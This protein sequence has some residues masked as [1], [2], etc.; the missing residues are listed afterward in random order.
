MASSAPLENNLADLY[1]SAPALPDGGKKFLVDVAP[2]LAL[3]AGLLSLWSAYGIWHWARAASRVADYVNNISAV[4][5][6][7]AVLET[8]WT[9][10]L[11]LA[12]IVAT[13]QAILMIAAFSGLKAR[14]KQGWNL[15]YYSLLLNL[16][17]GIVLMFTSYGGFGSLIA[18]LI[19]SA[20]GLYF[21]FQI[22]SSYNGGNKHV[23]HKN[24]DKS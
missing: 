11:W 20:I 13:I 17:Y 22:R 18:A 16:A 15:L 7:G 1:K 4:Y 23:D 12:L 6:S 2:W 9:V 19:G 24:A 5:G 3:I 8:R 14:K 21:L 10:T